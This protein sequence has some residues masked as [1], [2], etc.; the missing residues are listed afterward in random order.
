[1]KCCSK[2]DEHGVRCMPPWFGRWIQWN[3]VVSCFEAMAA[4]LLPASVTQWSCGTCA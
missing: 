4:A 3:F 2:D 1:V